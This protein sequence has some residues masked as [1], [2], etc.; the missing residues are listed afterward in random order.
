[1]D[2]VKSEGGQPQLPQTQTIVL[3]QAPLNWSAPGA[4]C[5]GA[6][7]SA[8]LFLEATAVETIMPTLALGSTQASEGGWCPS[9]PPH[10]P[11]SA[12]QLAGIV[13][14][15]SF[16]PQPNGASMEGGLATSQSTASLNDSCNPKS[17]YENFQ[18]W[19]RFKALARKHLPQSPDAD[20][21]ACFLM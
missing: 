10:A 21:L 18:R 7:C 12:A 15:V 14:Q 17:T 16:G 1:M 6:V 19:Q 4:L 2:Q 20:A 11:P 13:P 3:T 9:L 5:G 8:P